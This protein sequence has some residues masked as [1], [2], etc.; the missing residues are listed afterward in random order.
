[1]GCLVHHSDYRTNEDAFYHL[2]FYAVI[3]H[4]AK[5]T[6]CSLST[7]L[8][9]AFCVSLRYLNLQQSFHPTLMQFHVRHIR[10]Y[11][12]GKLPFSKDWLK[13]FSWLQLSSMSGIMVLWLEG[14]GAGDVA[15]G[16][17]LWWGP[18]IACNDGLFTFSFLLRF[19]LSP[20]IELG[21]WIRW[22]L[23]SYMATDANLRY[24]ENN[25]KWGSYA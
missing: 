5:S 10:N 19:P 7:C 6:I 15:Q 24:A 3:F 1:M 18:L 17:V 16:I 14:P 22:E 13:M 12:F 25:E 20:D 23:K 8:H 2:S 11:L 21:K 9:Y 4:D